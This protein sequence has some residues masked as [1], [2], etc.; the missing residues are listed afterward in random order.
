MDSSTFDHARH[1]SE[2]TVN[3]TDQ[4]K[5]AQHTGHPTGHEN[6]PSARTK[7]Q[8]T[9]AHMLRHKCPYISGILAIVLVIV[10]VPVM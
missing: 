5:M 10:L 8:R 2:A 9:R 3:T 7:A 1:N 6:L 4:E